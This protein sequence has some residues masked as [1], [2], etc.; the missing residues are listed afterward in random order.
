MR[1]ANAVAFAISGGWDVFDKSRGVVEHIEDILEAER[2]ENDD[3]II[4]WH[5]DHYFD[6]DQ[7]LREKLVRAKA[8]MDEA[9]VLCQEVLESV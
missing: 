6:P 3:P 8:L 7:E 2:A 1:S 9:E 5:E 4:E